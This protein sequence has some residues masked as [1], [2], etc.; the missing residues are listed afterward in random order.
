MR[1]PVTLRDVS[2]FYLPLIFTT[3]MMQI[4]HSVVNASLARLAAPKITLAG[5][6]V[7][8][9]LYH[10]LTS[11][12]ITG[13][14]LGISFLRDRAS[15][16][17]LV[18]FFWLVTAP[19][20]AVLLAV[21]LTPVGR[22]VFGGLLGASAEVVRQGQLAALVLAFN[23]PVLVFRHLATAVLLTNRRTH[24][25]TIGTAI[26]LTVL[27]AAVVAWPLVLEGS[28]VGALSITT[29]Q[30]A[31]AAFAVLMAWPYYRRLPAA[32]VD[33]GTF[34]DYW[35]FGWP[36]F[37]G[38]AAENGV[39]FTINFFLGRLPHPDLALAA[40]GV[41]NSV[42]RMLLAP[43]RNL[44]QTAQTLVRTREDLQVVL[45]FTARAVAIATVGCL[46]LFLLPSRD[47]VL[48]GAMGLTGELRDY[49]VPAVAVTFLVALFWGY[50]A[51]FKGLLANL[52]R[53]NA[54]G[55][56]APLRFAAIVVVMSLIFVTPGI[57]G[58]MLGVLAVGA[59]FLSEALLLGWRLVSLHRRAP[60]PLFPPA[61]SEPDP[62]PA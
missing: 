49:S 26:R 46:L 24:L 32:G 9:S 10:T 34:A 41:V 53:T 18:L 16:W 12:S 27:A 33:E 7:A 52:R 51:L 14:T 47:W 40:W 57:N 39:V 30:W 48:E 6:N 25:I 62:R 1:Q 44:Q 37:I 35:R 56:A 3:E 23:S 42:M 28:V 50:A 61:A 8:F 21:A 45:R 11:P 31:E 59:A 5:Y 17:R 4:S 38:L 36:V 13:P 20:V 29:C 19:S 22:W 54:I 43:L 60:E 55:A 2:A 15:A 58:A